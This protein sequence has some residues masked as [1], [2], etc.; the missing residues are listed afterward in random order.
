MSNSGST[1]EPPRTSGTRGPTQPPRSQPAR[2]EGRG[3]GTH[4]VG[5]RNVN[6][7]ISQWGD[8]IGSRPSLRLLL[9]LMASASRDNDDPPRYWGGVNHLAA[10]MGH[11]GTRAVQR[12]LAEL[13]AIGAVRP[14]SSAHRGRRQQYAIVLRR[15]RVH[16]SATQCV[17]EGGDIGTK[18]V[19]ATT[20]PTESTERHRKGKRRS[21]A[22]EP[23]PCGDVHDPRTPCRACAATRRE[24]E[25]RRREADAASRRARLQRTTEAIASC[26]RCDSRGYLPSGRVCPHADSAPMPATL[27]ALMGGTG[28]EPR[29]ATD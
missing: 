17:P 14:L 2:A 25:L 28:Q 4:T 20:T 5:A 13:I 26:T 24:G 18:S 16:Q 7:A 1:N 22:A 11:H 23:Q 3:R 8:A 10:L 19:A 6:A 21:P 29:A 27:R 15:E 12:Q 9:A